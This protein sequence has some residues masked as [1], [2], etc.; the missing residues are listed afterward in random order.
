[1]QE[2]LSVA[3]NN[4]IEKELSSH[5]SWVLNKYSQELND[6]L[7]KGEGFFEG[8]S[9]EDFEVEKFWGINF[10]VFRLFEAQEQWAKRKSKK[11]MSI[12]EVTPLHSDT[13]EHYYFEVEYNPTTKKI[14]DYDATGLYRIDFNDGDFIY[15]AQ[16]VTGDGRETVAD[17]V[18]AGTFDGYIKLN[19]PSISRKKSSL[20]SKKALID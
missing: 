17:G 12:Q 13:I 19:K 5:A 9:K 10:S 8:K 18:I 15:L 6:R 20:L 14:I 3:S 1:M 4:T 16:W 2:I 7:T 11:A